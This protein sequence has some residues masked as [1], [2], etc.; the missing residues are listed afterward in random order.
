MLSKLLKHELRATG[1]IFLPLYLLLVVFTAIN[2]FFVA[3]GMQ[4]LTM[5]DTNSL[6]A[7]MS[8]FIEVASITLY[9]IIIAAIFIMTL[10]VT[11]MRFYKN[12]LGEEGYLM[13]TLPVT[14]DQHIVSKLLISLLW[15]I[16]SALVAVLSIFILVV[17]KDF[18]RELN[19]LKVEWALYYSQWTS[20]VFRFSFETILLFLISAVSSVLVIYAAIM[21]GSQASKHRLLASFGVYIGFGVA[22]NMITSMVTGIFAPQIETFFESFN[23]VNV[24]MLLQMFHF[25]FIS[26]IIF[27]IIEMVVFYFL[28]RQMLKKRLNLD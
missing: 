1:R 27:S 12:L 22:T 24:E 16:L 7:T 6:G 9:C 20:H 25:I 3:R 10:V 18:F 21:V 2:R 19:A 4:G 17:N 13:N 23:D 8:Q 5:D 14:V 15:Q 11:V 28:T 26:G